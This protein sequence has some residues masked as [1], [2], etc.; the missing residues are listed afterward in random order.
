MSTMIICSSEDLPFHNEKLYFN[1]I[2]NSIFNHLI[3]GNHL[4]H[5]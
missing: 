2:V 5:K 1:F 4:G 3:T